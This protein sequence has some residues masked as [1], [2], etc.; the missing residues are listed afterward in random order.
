MHRNKQVLGKPQRMLWHPEAHKNRCCYIPSL[1]EPRVDI[2]KEYVEGHPGAVL[3]GP[4]TH[5]RVKKKKKKQKKTA[6]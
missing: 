6:N 5:P 1:K 4:E 2:K 3:L